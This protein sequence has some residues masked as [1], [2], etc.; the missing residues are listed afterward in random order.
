M[1]SCTA[2]TVQF[3]MQTQQRVWELNATSFQEG[4]FPDVVVLEKTLETLAGQWLVH[5]S[6][7]SGS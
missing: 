6:Y 2:N 5:L 3:D 1:T 4:F 7:M